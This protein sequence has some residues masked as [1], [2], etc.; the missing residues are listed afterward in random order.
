MDS[1]LMK[2]KLTYLKVFSFMFLF[3]SSPVVFGDILQDRPENDVNS[4]M[5]E[6][7]LAFTSKD[8]KKVCDMSLPLAQN[9][10][11]IAQWNLGNCYVKGQG[12]EQDYKQA[13]KWYLLSAKQGHK[14]SQ[15]ELEITF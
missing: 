1:Y 9:G 8:F 13:L 2:T 7:I 10:D 12:V 11:Q 3:S 14:R 5:M 6:I 15:N 4:K